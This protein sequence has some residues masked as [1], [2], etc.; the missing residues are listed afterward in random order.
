MNKTKNRNAHVG[1]MS[2][3]DHNKFTCD[4]QSSDHVNNSIK[5]E[6]WSD[7]EPLSSDLSTPTPY[8]INAFTGLLRAVIEAVAYYAQVPLAM[9]GQCVLGALAHI[10]QRFVNSPL[11]HNMPTS[12]ILITEGE[13]GSGKTQTMGLTHFKIKEHESQQYEKYL[14]DLA[15]W[16]ADKAGL[17][18]ADLKK[19]LNDMPMPANPKAL[20]NEATIEPILDMFISGQIT[21]AS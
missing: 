6:Q 20:F 18:G 16:E 5:N 15:T 14:K 3:A 7:P 8:P 19:Y 4:C 2:V 17:K 11:G 12:L 13:S 1:S 10:G 21:N 9:A